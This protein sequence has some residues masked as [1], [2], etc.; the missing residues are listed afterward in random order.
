MGFKPLSLMR[1]AYKVKIIFRFYQV[2]DKIKIRHHL[3]MVKRV[4]YMS[5]CEVAVSF[6]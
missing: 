3:Y 6:C 5:K 2:L 4:E 1:Y